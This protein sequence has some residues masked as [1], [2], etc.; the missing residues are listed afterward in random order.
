MKKT[1]S[2]GASIFAKFVQEGLLHQ[3]ILQGII[4]SIQVKKIIV[5]RIRVALNDLV[6]TITAYSIIERI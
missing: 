4:E 1:L 6:D 3:V 5:V 2:N